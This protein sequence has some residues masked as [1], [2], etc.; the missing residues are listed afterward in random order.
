MSEILYQ[1]PLHWLSYQDVVPRIL[2]KELKRRYGLSFIAQSKVFRDKHSYEGK[3]RARELKGVRL[4]GKEYESELDII[5][6]LEY[7]LSEALRIPQDCHRELLR[8]QEHSLVFFTNYRVIQVYC[9]HHTQERLQIEKLINLHG[10]FLKLLRNNE[11][12]CEQYE[13]ITAAAFYHSRPYLAWE[14]IFPEGIDMEALSPR[15]ANAHIRVK[16][17]MQK[18]KPPPAKVTA[19][20]KD[21]PPPP[22]A[23]V[24]EPPSSDRK[25]GAIYK[26][27]RL[28]GKGGF[29]ICYEGQLAGTKQRYALKIVKSHM[30]QKKME[31]KVS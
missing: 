10:K 26:T 20:E 9:S 18:A 22:P 15:D 28:L 27:G 19:K 7:I 24:W 1:P 25:D 2:V 14:T 29:A 13:A 16:Q 21:H 30:P 17:T 5:N 11:V 8:G 12:E 4:L 3:T 23:E 6:L 31:Q